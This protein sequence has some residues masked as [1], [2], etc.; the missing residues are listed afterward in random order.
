MSDDILDEL[1]DCS[2]A[3]ASQ[4]SHEALGAHNRTTETKNEARLQALAALASRIRRG[5]L[6]DITEL[7]TDSTLGKARNV[8]LPCVGSL[9]DTMVCDG[10]TDL[11]RRERSSAAGQSKSDKP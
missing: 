3:N 9:V 11:L 7:F 6:P 10:L 5:D 8:L 4:P 1:S 2:S